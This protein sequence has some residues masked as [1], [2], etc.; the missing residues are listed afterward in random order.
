MVMSVA[1]G[2]ST[3]VRRKGLVETMPQ[4]YRTFLD[5]LQV[6][7]HKNTAVADDLLDWCFYSE[8]RGEYVKKDASRSAACFTVL[9]LSMR[10][11]IQLGRQRVRV[12]SSRPGVPWL[13]SFRKQ[14]E[15]IKAAA[16]E[17][18]VAE[19]IRKMEDSGEECESFQVR[20]RS[21]AGASALAEIER[22]IAGCKAVFKELSALDKDIAK[23]KLDK[24]LKSAE[25]QP[26]LQ[27]ARTRVE[28]LSQRQQQLLAATDSGLFNALAKRDIPTA[29]KYA[30]FLKKQLAR[31]ESA[32]TSRASSSH[33]RR[34][35]AA[36]KLLE[37][38]RLKIKVHYKKFSPVADYVGRDDV[39]GGDAVAKTRRGISSMKSIERTISRA[40]TSSRL[41]K[42][43]WCNGPGSSRTTL[44]LE[45]DGTFYW[46][47]RREG[48][49]LGTWRESSGFVYLT[50]NRGSG[51]IW[52]QMQNRTSSFELVGNALVMSTGA[53]SITCN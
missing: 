5:N 46:D 24:V 44:N 7:A 11:S 40:R 33:C 20:R 47:V 51:T 9:E 31:G 13:E 43:R 14:S 3:G 48:S 12:G 28:K 38:E 37:N 21:T 27:A 39:C 17:N 22:S 52:Y 2:V 4:A 49:L 32:R 16:V 34:L 36:W 19:A 41:A 45:R 10:K 35:D 42:T 53:G 1:L 23:R 26:R 50:H 30:A 25:N 29:N 15:D 18:R 8:S 6:Y